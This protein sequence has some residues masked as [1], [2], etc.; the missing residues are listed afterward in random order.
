MD[1][2]PPIAE[3]LIAFMP[4]KQP[5]LATDRRYLVRSLRPSA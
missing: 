2:Y 4:A 1:R 5:Q 3:Q